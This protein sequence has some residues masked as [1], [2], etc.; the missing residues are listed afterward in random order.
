MNGYFGIGIVSGKTP[1]NFGMLWWSAYQ[2]GASFL[3]TVGD[4]YGSTRPL[5]ATPKE[6]LSLPVW[7]FDGPEDFRFPFDCVPVAVEKGGAPLREFVHPLRAIYMMGED[8][9]IPGWAR[10]TAA[11][12]VSIPAARTDSFNVVAAGA[13]VMADRLSKLGGSCT[14]G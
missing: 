3:F 10:R 11:C 8:H 1:I 12:A 6:W 5:D 2:L 7:R 9:R 14:H 13:L 4:R